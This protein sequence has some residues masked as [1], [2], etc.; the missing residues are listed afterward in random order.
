[1]SQHVVAAAVSAEPVLHGWRSREGLLG[2]EVYRIK[3]VS[4][5]GPHRPTVRRYLPHNERV[6]IV[7]RGFQFAP[8]GDFA[9]VEHEWRINMALIA[10]QQR[11]FVGDHIG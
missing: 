6:L 10:H 1:M 3:A 7:R 8:K 9:V 2:I 4:D 11:L 5:G